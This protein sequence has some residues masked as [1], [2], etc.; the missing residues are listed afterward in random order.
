M[1]I[2]KA[3][4]VLVLSQIFPCL[5]ML[6]ALNDKSSPDY[7]PV[8]VCYVAGWVIQIIAVVICFVIS[9]CIN[10]LGK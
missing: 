1:K 5:S 8:S 6:S 7:S 3:L 9:K 10:E 2:R 4:A